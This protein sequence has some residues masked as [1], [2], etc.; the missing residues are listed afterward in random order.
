MALVQELIHDGFVF[1]G[2]GREEVGTEFLAEVGR[3]DFGAGVAV[4]GE[5]GG[6]EVAEIEGEEG[7]KGFLFGEVAGGSYDYY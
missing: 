7:G 4:N 1:L 3:G 6:E 2:S 5:I